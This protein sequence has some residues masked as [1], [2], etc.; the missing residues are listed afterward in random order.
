MDAFA[1]GSVEL[2]VGAL[3]RRCAHLLEGA[4]SAF[5][6]RWSIFNGV[7]RRAEGLTGPAG[8][9]ILGMPWLARETRIS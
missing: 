8:L 3:G 2:G 1:A 5:D 9:C 4:A 7:R 6:R